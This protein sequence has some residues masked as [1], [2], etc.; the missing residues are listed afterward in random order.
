M[1]V[2][3]GVYNV[4][5]WQPGLRNSFGLPRKGFCWH[6]VPAKISPQKYTNGTL[7]SLCD[8]KY[9]DEKI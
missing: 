6:E 9:L 1:G 5:I 7:Y 2:A 4:I 3:R 8:F